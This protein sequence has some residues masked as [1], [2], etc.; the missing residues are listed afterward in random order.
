MGER[1][2]EYP[3]DSASTDLFLHPGDAGM[4]IL[5][6]DSLMPVPGFMPSEQN[7]LNELEKKVQQLRGKNPLTDYW[8]CTLLL[9][10][11]LDD[12]AQWLPRFYGDITDTS[13]NHL[14]R[15]Y[16]EALILYRSLFIHPRIIYRG[17]PAEITNYSDFMELS[18]K[19][20]DYTERRNR[21][22]RL[23]GNTYWWHYYFN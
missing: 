3:I 10:K 15:H 21:T 22:R 4:M 7:Y 8:L 6:P 20:S 13:G 17:T 12:F 19:Y 9:Q 1:L 2:F 11:R 16:R 18:E 23:Y 14:P 5:P